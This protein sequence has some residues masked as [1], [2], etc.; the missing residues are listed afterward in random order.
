VLGWE[1]YDR[2]LLE[3]VAQDIG[4]RTNLLESVD[5]RRQSWLLEASEALLSEPGQNVAARRL[6]QA[7]TEALLCR[8]SENNSSSSRAPS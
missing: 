4:L 2:E 5:E 6:I 3:K 7:R 1:V 8:T